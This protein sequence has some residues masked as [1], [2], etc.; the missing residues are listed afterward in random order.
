MISQSELSRTAVPRRVLFLNWRGP[1][2]PDAGGA[3]VY[4]WAMATRF[5]KAGMD[6]TLFTARESGAPP[7]DRIEGVHVVRA[8]GTFSIYLHAAAYL[9]R[10]RRMYDAVVDCQNG[11][12]FFAPLWLL[13]TDVAIVTL[14]HH[15]HQE[16]FRHRFGPFVA[17]IGRRLEREVSRVVYGGRPIVGVSPSTRAEIRLR[18][19]LRGPIFIVPNGNHVAHPRTAAVR[20]VEPL[21]VFIGRLVPHKR[22]ELLLEAMP[23]LLRRWPQLRLEVAGD[24]P[25]LAELRAMSERLRLGAAVVFHGR[26]TEQQRFDLM[27]RGWLTVVPSAREGWGLTIIEANAAGRPAIGFLVPGVRDAIV[28]GRTGWLVRSETELV[29]M[30]DEAIRTLAQPACAIEVSEACRQWAQCFSWDVSADRLALLVESEFQR[31]H[32]EPTARRAR[33]VNDCAVVATFD[34]DP[35]VGDI[36][37][38]LRAGDLVHRSAGHI[39]LVLPGS[40]SKQAESVLQRLRVK[41]E[42]TLRAA[43]GKDLLGLA[44]GL[45]SRFATRPPALT[46]GGEA[47]ER[48]A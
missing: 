1:S 31:G 24:G 9:L 35:T 6:V 32:A 22:L 18:L 2:H 45:E 3:E 15:V 13:G 47:G 20:S 26:V 42:V 5:A 36:D 48:A 8:G 34:G 10:H 40:D 12:P 4:V 16:Q 39:T 37:R 19:G 43:S 41:A 17:W 30:L 7:E 11:I 33:R 23:Q 28:D 44:E 46:D 21:I 25:A 29:D 38:R 27:V 14:I